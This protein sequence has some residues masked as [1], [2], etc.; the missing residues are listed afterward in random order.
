MI[1][2]WLEIRKAYQEVR[3]ALFKFK[4]ADFVVTLA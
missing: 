1:L 4:Y 3:L 2:A